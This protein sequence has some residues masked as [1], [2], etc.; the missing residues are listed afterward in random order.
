MTKKARDAARDEAV[1]RLREW[2]KPGD[3]VYT[4]LRHVSRSGMQREISLVKLTGADAGVLALDYNAAQLLGRRI[5]K[6]DGIIMGG[7]GMDMGFALVYELSA[8]LWPEGFDC[9]GPVYYLRDDELRPGDYPHLRTFDTGDSEGT[10]YAE[11]LE[12]APGFLPAY[13]GTD[14][15]CPASD[16]SNRE[17]KF[18]HESGGYALR[19]RWL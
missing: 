17:R 1:V 4:I 8:A 5:G 18:H 14:C 7:C 13:L 16:H 12:G 15:R 3:T 2:L 19:Q 9:L 10:V 11:P 6:R